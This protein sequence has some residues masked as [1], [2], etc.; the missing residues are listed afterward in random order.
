MDLELSGQAYALLREVRNV[1]Y[2]WISEVQEK[3][4]FVQDETSR[5]SLRHRL[6][7]LATTCF[8]TF[9]VSPEHVAAVLAN[10]ED[11]SIA[12]QCAIIVHEN[13]PQSLSSNYSY[14]LTRLLSRHRRLLH[15]L[16]PIFGQSLLPI[17]G[18]VELSHGG[19]Y[20]DA[21]ARSRSGYH[22]GNSSSWHSLPRPNSRWISCITGG[23]QKVY[24]DLL[25]GKLIIG[26][27]RLGGLPPEIVKHPTYASV[28]G[29]VSVG[30]HLS[31]ALSDLTWGAF[32]EFLMCRLLMIMEWIIWLDLPNLG[33][34]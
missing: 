29:T 5:A 26:E 16:E 1:T 27:K 24:Y 4:N 21:L 30:H 8:S 2:R 18:R 9:D 3:S 31:A 17:S 32:R 15:N 20:D 34:R 7:I 22:Q 12:M 25:T 23:G 14:H 11:F 28:L 33:I 10:E 19:A 6:C 13:T